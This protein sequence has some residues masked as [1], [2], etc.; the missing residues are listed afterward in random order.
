[1]GRKGGRGDRTLGTTTLYLSEARVS[2]PVFMRSQTATMSPYAFRYR[3]QQLHA[4]EDGGVATKFPTLSVEYHISP[5]HLQV[6]RGAEL[7]FLGAKH[8]SQKSSS[9]G[10]SCL[11]CLHCHWNRDIGTAVCA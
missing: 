7:A 8:L 5:T 1:M 6:S 4:M 2:P 11:H 3:V 10:F 9:S